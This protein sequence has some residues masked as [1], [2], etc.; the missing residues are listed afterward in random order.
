M[1]TLSCRTAWALSV[2]PVPLHSSVLFTELFASKSDQGKCFQPT[3][4]TY[5]LIMHNTFEGFA[6]EVEYFSVFK[7]S[8]KMTTC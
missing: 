3:L 5:S 8:S 6:M 2:G 7:A 4:E 1:S